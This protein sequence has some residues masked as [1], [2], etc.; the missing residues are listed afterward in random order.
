M[1]TRDDETGQTGWAS[2]RGYMG[3]TTARMLAA[4]GA[5][6]KH[7]GQG[8]EVVCR[9]QSESSFSLCV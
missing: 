2:C 4:W 8:L 7:Q 1:K 5:R 9:Q 3:T 6:P